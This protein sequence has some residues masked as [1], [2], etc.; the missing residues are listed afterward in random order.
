MIKNLKTQ[1]PIN[2]DILVAVYIYKKLII[3]LKK[4]IV[5]IL[6]I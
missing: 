2:L 3:N 1:L 6:I 5:P 4:K